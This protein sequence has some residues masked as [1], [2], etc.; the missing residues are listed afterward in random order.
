[1]PNNGTIQYHL[2]WCTKY[3]KD[4]LT[5]EVQIELKR[6]VKEKCEQRGHTL[7]EIETMP[8]HVHC[9]VI[10]D[11][12]TTA[13]SVVSQIKGY[14]A[15]RLRKKFKHLT[16][17]L[18]CLWTRSYYCDTIGHIS[19]DVVKRYIQEQKTK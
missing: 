3:R 11:S 4:V 10:T 13:H 18:P 14:T 2:V 7:G 16:T 15:N 19:E 17:R 1:M 9:F 8:D 5:E 6:L 12:K